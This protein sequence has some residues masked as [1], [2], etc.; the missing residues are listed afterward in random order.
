[1]QFVKIWESTVLSTKLQSFYEMEE[2]I[3]QSDVNGEN[4]GSL[5]ARW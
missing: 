5:M 1:M 4:Y 3:A 2:N